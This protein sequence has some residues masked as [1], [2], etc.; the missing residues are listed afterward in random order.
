MVSMQ[1][2]PAEAQI[3]A[4]AAR[5]YNTFYE[6]IKLDVKAFSFAQEFLHGPMESENACIIS[7]IRMFGLSGFDLLER[8]AAEEYG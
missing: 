5:P 1:G 4:G 7:D 8:L 2:R 6:T 3:R